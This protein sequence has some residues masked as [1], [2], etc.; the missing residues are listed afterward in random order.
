MSELPEAPEPQP[1]YLGPWLR[2]CNYS[3]PAEELAPDELFGT[4][5]MIVGAGGEVFQRP[6]FVPLINAQANGA[7][8]LTGIGEQV[9]SA[10]STAT[11]CVAG[12]QF[13]EN[14]SGTWTD[15][16]NGE[17]I[18]AGSGNLWSFANANGVMVG[19]NG[20]NGDA[21][22]HWSASGNLTSGG[23]TGQRVTWATWVEWWDSRV[24]LGNS[25]DGTDRTN[26]TS[27]T[28]ITSAAANDWFS[29]GQVMNGQKA[30]GQQALALHGET[31]IQLLVPT[32]N[33]SIP[34]RRIGRSGKGTVAGR[35]IVTVA[36]PGLPLMQLFVRK[37]GIYRFTGGEAE[38][39]S[40]K[41]DGERFW[42]SVNKDQ[43][44][45]SFASENPDRNEVWFFLPVGTSQ[46]TY[47]QIIV[48]NYLRDIWYG[49]HVVAS[50]LYD[51]WLC[52]APVGGIIHAGGYSDSG[53]AYKMDFTSK[54]NDDQDGTTTAAIAAEFTTGAPPPLGAD[55]MNRYLYARS[56]YDITGNYDVNLTHFAPGIPASTKTFNQGGGY[57]AI[58]SAFKIGTSQ[59]AGEDLMA[60]QDTDLD[61][62]DPTIQLTYANGASLEEFSIRRV[63]V[64]FRPLGRQ[65]K[66]AAGVF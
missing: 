36:A 34:Y 44:A 47:N 66:S 46:T 39:I 35:S 33:A 50:A 32:H 2:G 20:V 7:S 43:L 61:G 30:F 29:I 14:V 11:F 37:D 12:N 26:Y 6:G 55:V 51:D 9:F 24:W 52:A 64:M 28:D 4:T 17:T 57:D 40:W 15:R 19:C 41:L 54:L 3:L 38:K 53:R 45:D 60:S 22:L 5:N 16:T 56:S 31:V 63:A 13:L 23:L 65:R 48:Y 42:D 18:T 8:H 58:E 59:I 10:A 25:D 1:H 49:P 62:Y 27:N 21:L